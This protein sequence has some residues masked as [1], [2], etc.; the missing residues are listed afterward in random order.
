MAHRRGFAEAAI[1]AEWASIVGPLLSGRC[2]P[3]R[4][5]FPRGRAKGGTLELHAR[6]GAAL[7]LQHLAP[8]VV[9]R[10]NAYFGFA[11]V[12]RIRLVQGTP[13]PPRGVTARRSSVPLRPEEENEL[14]EMVGSLAEE[15][16]GRALL[17]L[18]RQ[19]RRPRA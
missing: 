14:R 12:R 1:L 7:E 10:V 11:A 9:E 3:V 16:L 18:G 4:V 6:G 19:M 8:Q 2:Q 17:E 13:P 5:D 15:P